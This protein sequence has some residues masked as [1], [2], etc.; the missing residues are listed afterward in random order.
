[1]ADQTRLRQLCLVL[2]NIRELIHQSKIDCL[3]MSW[4]TFI[5]AYEFLNNANRNTLLIKFNTVLITLLIPESQ[6]LCHIHH[7]I[8]V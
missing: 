3:I 7:N 6:S 5:W 1:M 4:L 2:Y 8:L